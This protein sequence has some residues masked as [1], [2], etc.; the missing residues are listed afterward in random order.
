MLI[1]KYAEKS[2][3][4]FIINGLV[5]VFIPM[6]IGTI[7]T[8]REKHPFDALCIFNTGIGFVNTKNNTLQYADFKDIELSYGRMQQS[9]Y[10]KSTSTNIKKHEYNW[11][12]F[13]HPDVL[14]NNLERYGTV[15]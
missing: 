5:F 7:V 3:T 14:R 1:L 11:I 9:F 6:A 12:E 8:Y 13:D 15:S 4:D 10:I 2:K